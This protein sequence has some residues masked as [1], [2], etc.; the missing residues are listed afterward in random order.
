MCTQFFRWQKVGCSPLCETHHHQ[1]LESCEA[2][3]KES[4]ETI[5]LSYVFCFLTAS[6]LADKIAEQVLT[7][8]SVHLMEF[9]ESRNSGNTWLSQMDKGHW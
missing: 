8:F 5:G 1:E 9:E 2:K 7:N 4:V 6:I 3:S